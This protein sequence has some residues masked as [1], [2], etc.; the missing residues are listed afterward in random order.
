MKIS[1]LK[2]ALV[3]CALSLSACTSLFEPKVESEEIEKNQMLSSLPSLSHTTITTSGS[4]VYS[5]LGRGADAT[6][7]Q[8]D[9]GDISL[10]LVSTTASNSNGKSGSSEGSHETEMSGRTPT[11][12]LAREFFY[13]ACEFSHNY[14][15]SKEEA[16]S[17]YLKTMSTVSERW[18]AETTNNTITIGDTLGISDTNGTTAEDIK[19]PDTN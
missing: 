14:K 13:R 7:G 2:V 15:L 1:A 8:S 17:L 11:V 10:A 9:G 12:L 5:C 18:Q 6:F 16:L 3:C 4:D 19:I